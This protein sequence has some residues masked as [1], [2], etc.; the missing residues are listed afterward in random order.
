MKKAIIKRFMKLFNRHCGPE[1]DQ[2]PKHVWLRWY[3][4]DGDFYNSHVTRIGG[5]DDDFFFNDFCDVSYDLRKGSTES[6]TNLPEDQLNM[7]Y[8]FSAGMLVHYRRVSC[9]WGVVGL[10]IQYVMV[11]VF[12]NVL[13]PLRRLY[14]L[15]GACVLYL[16]IRASALV[17]FYDRL[18]VISAVLF[19]FTFLRWQ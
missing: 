19:L 5:D 9:Y 11:P 4:A 8:R 10:A 16:K 6:L 1:D 17:S 14:I 12:Y 3:G 7:L 13:M 15:L 2:M 18:F